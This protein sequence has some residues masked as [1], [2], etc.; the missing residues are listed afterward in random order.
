MVKQLPVNRQHPGRRVV[1]AEMCAHGIALYL[2]PLLRCG[3]KCKSPLHRKRKGS[4]VEVIKNKTG[5]R[6]VGQ[7]RWRAIN[8][9]I[10]QPADP[11]HQRQRAVSQAVKL[12]QPA[13]F[14]TRGHQDHIGT[15]DDFVR[16]R[17]IVTNLDPDRV[18]IT[19][20]G[21]AECI[22]QP[23]VAGAQQNQLATTRNDGWQR[24]Q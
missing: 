6:V 3:V 15:G 7:C 8:H 21:F 18:R 13:R 9:R 1:P 14:K 2:L 16:T 10:C 24:S 22:L 4:L 23:T 11:A 12:G 20:G 19:H 17:F 5:A